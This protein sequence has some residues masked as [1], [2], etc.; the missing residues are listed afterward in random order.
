MDLIP[1][2]ANPERDWC[3]RTKPKDLGWIERDWRGFQLS[4][5]TPN[6]ISSKKST[7]EKEQGEQLESERLL[8]AQIAIK[9]HAIFAILI[10]SRSFI[11]LF[12]LLLILMSHYMYYS[13]CAW[14]YCIFDNK[15]RK[16]DILSLSN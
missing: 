4:Q 8:S 2:H 11:G 1:I 10:C 7:T 16:D 12:F 9:R 14:N 3:K 13:C 6:P 5:S 15:Q